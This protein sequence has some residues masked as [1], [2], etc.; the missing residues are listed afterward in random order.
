MNGSLQP[1]PPLGSHDKVFVLPEENKGIVF[2]IG[3]VVM[4]EIRGNPEAPPHFDEWELRAFSGKWI[5]VGQFF[6][7]SPLSGLHRF[8]LA[9]VQLQP[10]AAQPGAEFP[11]AC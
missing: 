2:S 11:L 3:T 7:A 6:K 9:W 5:N 10:A 8:S 1:G 4:W